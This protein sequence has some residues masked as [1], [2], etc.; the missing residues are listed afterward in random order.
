MKTVNRKK[1]TNTLHREILNVETHHNHP[2]YKDEGGIFRWKEND[3]VIKKVNEIGLNN[4]IELFE[5]LGLN[6]NS[7]IVRK[8][9]RDIG[10]SL[11][12]YYDIFYWEVNNPIA[13][14]YKPNQMP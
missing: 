1:I 12:G 9:Y 4:I 13:I 11:N 14:D 8:M 3:F 10:Y 7:E 5:S 2:I 6:K